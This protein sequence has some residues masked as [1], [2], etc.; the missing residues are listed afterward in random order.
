MSRKITIE[1]NGQKLTGYAQLIQ[2]KLWV[3]HNGL[4]LTAESNGGPRKR[5][6]AEGKASTSQIV[7]PM[8]GKITKIFV[9]NNTEIE[10]GQAVVVMEA[11]KMEY[12]LKSELTTTV[13]NV[14]VKLGDQVQLGQT[15]VKLKEINVQLR[16]AKDLQ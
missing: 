3:H 8:P 15:L 13:E 1:I 5:R 14:L 16:E 10:I 2:G 11:M 9:E 7:A 12:T 4:T 6:S